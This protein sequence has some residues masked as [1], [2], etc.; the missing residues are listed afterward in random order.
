MN[1][2]F[3]HMKGGAGVVARLDLR[4]CRGKECI[5]LR[6]CLGAKI[7]RG[8]RGLAVIFFRQSVDL[9][10]VENAVSACKAAIF[11]LAG[12]GIQL[13]ETPCGLPIK[14]SSRHFQKARETRRSQQTA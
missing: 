5:K 8:F 9:A 3:A 10:G 4:A 13:L 12:L 1:A 11:L 6:V 7:A 14:T 2:I